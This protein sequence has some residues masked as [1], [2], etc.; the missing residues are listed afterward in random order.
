MGEKF[1]YGEKF[2][3]HQ[4]IR[5]QRANE[6]ISKTYPQ[7][8]VVV[9]PE[10][11]GRSSHEKNAI[12]FPMQDPHHDPHHSCHLPGA[13]AAA[14]AGLPFLNVPQVLQVSVVEVKRT[15]IGPHKQ[16]L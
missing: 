16:A 2:L 1:F 8:I 11:A 4:K 3:G 12:V 6:A 14:A 7:T 5:H 15:L 13:A 10:P 9:E